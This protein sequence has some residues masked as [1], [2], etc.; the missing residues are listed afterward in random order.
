[1]T[2]PAAHS[3]EMGADRYMGRFAPSPTGPLHAGSLL[4]AVASWLDARAASG[5]WLVRMEDI[6]GP[7]AVPGAA[8][9]ILQAL[10]CH[11]L[12]WDGE[13]VYQGDRLAVYGEVLAELDRA[14]WLYACSCSRRQLRGHRVYPGWCRNGPCL[15]DAPHALRFRVQDACFSRNDAIQGHQHIHL[16]DCGDFVV[17]RRDG[18]FAYQLAVVV[19]DQAQGITHVV[20]GLDLLDS[21][22]RQ[23][24]LQQALGY[25]TPS[26]AHLPL[27]INR[28]GDKLS[29]QNRAAPLSLTEPRPAM[30]AVLAAL[31]LPVDAHLAACSLSDILDW[32]RQHWSLRPLQGKTCIAA[33]TLGA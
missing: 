10:E 1:M 17:M 3:L 12:H 28:H 21:T 8:D 32:A 15:P 19:D 22:P 27:V 33:A 4:T 9:L 23:W 7:R 16:S 18:V 24:A 11:G 26:Y 14:G 31:G 13:V 29:K 2:S 6:D 25:R 5:H 30:L 20:R